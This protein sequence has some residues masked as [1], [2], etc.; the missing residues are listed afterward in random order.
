[1]KDENLADEHELQ[2]YFIQRIERFLNTKGRKLIGWDEILEG[3]LSETATVQ[4]W[5]GMQ[6]GQEAA[7][8]GNNVIMSPTSHCYLD[9]S[10][11]S[12]D[13]KKIYDFDPIPAELAVEHHHSIL[14]GECNMWTERVPDENNLDSKV[15]PRM[16]GLAEVLWT[17]PEE[18]NFEAFYKRLQKHY[19]VLTHFGIAYGLETIGAYLSQEFT[20][21][22][23]TIHLE[24]NLPDL[25]LKYRWSGEEH[26]TAY[27]QS[28]D[29][30]Q[31]GILSVQA[32]KN[33][34]PYGEPIE[35]R[36]KV[37]KGLNKPVT[38]EATYNQWYEGSSKEKSL[39]DGRIGS[40]DFRDGNW[41]GFWGKDGDF[42]IDL[43]TVQEITKIS[44][45]FY[46]YAN[47]WIFLPP[48]VEFMYSEN[49]EIWSPLDTYENASV[50]LSNQ[51]YTKMVSGQPVVG[52]K[53]FPKARYVRLK[54]SNLGKVPEGHEA[55]G[56]DA[57]L[58]IDEISIE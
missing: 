26:Y 9:Y 5:R 52:G 25:S 34:E 2:S 36:F 6:G 10:L 28:L 27:D 33:E 55:A 11:S 29:L 18:R 54:A 19:L 49:G 42:T 22:G 17:Y 15:F 3:G 35:Q 16:I 14:G 41:Q 30:N 58:F 24:R 50:D 38:Y 48:K 57:W 8:H 56:Q 7:E 21:E 39:T 12:I 23:I 20:N 40:V 46:Q 44:A 31:S 32:F 37:H 51:Q 53:G 45:N 4:S 43:G 1:M 47:S 13:L